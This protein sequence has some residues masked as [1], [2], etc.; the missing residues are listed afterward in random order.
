MKYGIIL[1]GL[2]KVWVCLIE[3]GVVYGFIFN[4]VD[5]MWMVNIFCVY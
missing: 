1:E 2:I 3:M 5:D 4:Y